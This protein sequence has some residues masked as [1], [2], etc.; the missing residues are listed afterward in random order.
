MQGYDYLTT[1]EAAAYLKLKERKLYDL[2]ARGE[3]PCSKV[4]GKWLFP[5][6][7]LDRWIASRL[8]A[9]AG[10]SVAHPPPIVGGSHDP[11]LE[12]VLRQSGSGLALL[13]EGSSAG[14]ARLAAG[15]VAIAAI[16]LHSPTTG[17]PNVAAV[18]A[19]PGLHDAIVVGFAVRDQG[20]VVAA[21][22]PLGLDGI[23]AAAKG[24]ARF[25]VR[26]AG[27]GA[28][29]LMDL[30]LARA[31]VALERLNVQTGV[32]A[33]GHDLAVAVRAGDIDCGLATRAVAAA[34]GLD[35]V[36]LATERFD[37]VMRRRTYFEPGPQKLFS[38]MRSSEFRSRAI[39]FQGYDL[40]D[41]GAIRFNG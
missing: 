34:N 33:T 11:L 26:Q 35:Y 9:P 8:A 31:G 29:L 10:F 20:L 36:P 24:G 15:E 41:A 13:S 28:R 37:L 2:A 18:S 32:F 16:H 17:D 22:N 6:P 14:L 30:L 39:L 1:E 23:A 3:V 21:G 25:G 12:W 38:A 7:A 4:T 27:A 5:R 19:S 40:A